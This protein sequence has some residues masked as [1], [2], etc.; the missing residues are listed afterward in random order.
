MS[1]VLYQYDGID[2]IY[3]EKNN[4]TGR[5]TRIQNSDRNSNPRPLVLFIVI[6]GSDLVTPKQKYGACNENR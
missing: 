4:T 3:Q 6:N 1:P 2:P 5:A